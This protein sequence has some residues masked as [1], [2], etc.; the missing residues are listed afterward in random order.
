MLILKKAPEGI[1]PCSLCVYSKLDIAC[2]S[3]N[4]GDLDEYLYPEDLVVIQK[5]E[6]DSLFNDMLK[7]RSLENAGVDNWEGYDF[8]MKHYRERKEFDNE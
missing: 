3:V 1:T 2:L 5:A 7:L 6:Y 8:A 4:C